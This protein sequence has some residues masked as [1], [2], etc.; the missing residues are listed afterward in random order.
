VLYRVKEKF[1]KK[2]LAALIVIIALTIT[3]CGLFEKGL[4]NFDCDISQDG[5]CIAI[6]VQGCN[7]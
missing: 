3:G 5:N 2:A 6:T 1:M 7:E 4:S